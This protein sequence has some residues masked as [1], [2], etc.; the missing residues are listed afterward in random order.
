MAGALALAACDDGVVAGE[1]DTFVEGVAWLGGP[2][3]GADVIAWQLV[4]ATGERGGERGRGVTDA[5][6]RFRIDL[7]G[8]LNTVELDV[9]GGRYVDVASGAAVTR[10]PEVL[11]GVAFDLEIGQTRTDVAV[12]PWSHLAYA[13]GDSR[14]DEAG[15]RLEAMR[16]GRALVG[17]HLGFDPTAGPIAPLDEASPSPTPPVRHALALAGLAMLGALANADGYADVTAER[18]AAALAADVRS[19]ERLLDGDGGARTVTAVCEAGPID[20]CD[21]TR[22][23]CAPAC[24]LTPHTLRSQLA[25]AIRAYLV[26]HAATGQ[27]AATLAT[28]LEELRTADEPRL[29]PPGPPEPLDVRGPRVRWLAPA[30]DGAEVAGMIGVEAIADDPIGVASLSLAVT[31]VGARSIA[32]LDGAAE[33]AR[34][35]LDTAAAGLPEGALV[36][37]ATATDRDGNVAHAERTIVADNRPGGAVSGVVVKGRIAGATVRVFAYAGGVR[38]ALLGQGATAADGSFANV[39]IADGYSG[40]LLVE[41]GGGGSYAEDAAPPGTPPATLDTADA[42]RTVIPAY[43]DG[44]AV[45]SAVVSPLTTFAVTYAAYLQAQAPADGFAPAWTTARDVIAAHFGVADPFAAVPSLPAAIG[46]DT[47]ADRH[48][49]VLIGLSQLAYRASTQGGGDAGSF[50]TAMDSMRVVRVLDQDLADGCLDGRA[51]AAPLAYGGTQ[52]PGDQTL[53]F[54]LAAA[55]ATYLA[56]PARDATALDVA[57]ALPLLDTLALGGPATGPGACAGGGLFPTPGGVFDREPPAIVWQAP[58]PDE[59]AWV[60]G[61]VIVRAGALDAIDPAPVVRWLGGLADTDGDPANAIATATIATA[62]LP[63]GPLAIAA[64]AIDAAGNRGALPVRT[65]HVD[66]TPPVVTVSPAGFHADG[67][68]LWT[69]AAAPIL[70]GAIAEAHLASITVVRGATAVAAATVTGGAWSAAIPPGT[71]TDTAGAVLRV[72]ARDRAGNVA[73]VTVRVRLDDTP[74]ALAWLPVAVRDEAGD[75]ITFSTAAAFGVVQYDPTHTHQGPPVAL[76]ASAACDASAP[77]VA[78]Y[79]YLLDEAPPPYVTEA[80]G[81]APGGRNPLRFQVALT[82][83][84]VG[85][86]PAT[87]TYR[88]R[89][90]AA[91]TTLLDWRPLP[92]ASPHTIPLHRRGFAAPSIPA[93]G[94]RA[95]LLALDVR[96]TDRLGRTTASTR[97]WHH[98]PLPAPV[99]VGPVGPAGQMLTCNASNC[100][101]THGPLG[102][103]KYALA[104]LSLGDTSP[105]FDP[106]GAQV[107]A[108]GAPGTALLQFPVYNPTTEPIAL[109]IDLAVPT[110]ATYTRQWVD[111]RW[112]TTITNAV[113][114][115]GY[116][117][118][119]GGPDTAIPDCTL[120]APA[121]SGAAAPGQHHAGR[122]DATVR[123]AGLG[124][125]VAVEP[126]RARPV[127]RLQPGR[128]RRHRARDDPPA[129]APAA[130]PRR[131]SGA[132]AQ[133]R[134]R[135]GRARHQRAAAARQRVVPRIHG[136]QRHAHRRDPRDPQRL[137]QPRARRAVA[138]GVPPDDD[139]HALPRARRDRLVRDPARIG[140][141]RDLARRHDAGAPAARRDP[142]ARDRRLPVVFDRATPAPRAVRIR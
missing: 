84:G 105:P 30:A 83:D 126:R 32:D 121:R 129:R 74:P 75:A 39:A 48:G 116:D 96:A 70:T 47:G 25:Q 107:L 81:P 22:S 131:R 102:S 79:A 136:R 125:A 87:A 62:A 9:I 130:E 49:L 35:T 17:A 29:F 98:R 1:A 78:K 104:A 103:G 110:G 3:E 123:R 137:L 6:G 15:G 113:H 26:G 117:P 13:I 36:L 53:R 119:T 21:A 80:N 11:H 56:D 46:G 95:A 59:G 8:T 142:R 134:R 54:E 61:D 135:P 91:G 57:D 97:C 82:D 138:L 55:I 111:G 10:G 41:A 14:G 85:L 90:V 23:A 115:C 69:A 45:A 28:W 86:D 52:R 7:G 5:G 64:E 66:N 65:V 58:T 124:G 108:T 92:G 132:A 141:V 133:A 33:R 18:F 67:A 112:G 88:V 89:D 128:P 40:P 37:R 20:A 44:G 99:L 50:A 100:V 34:G 19:A 101:A 2:I 12:T 38:G 76:G 109:T 106:I 122:G 94:E 140:H 73:A 4:S 27:S 77:A 114:D 118:S 16:S 51:G 43:E 31:G 72:E 71:I 68:D 60:R 42:L 24:R 120:V 63:D 93:L 139:L 127:R